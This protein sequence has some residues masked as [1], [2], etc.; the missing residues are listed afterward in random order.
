MIEAKISPS[1]FVDSRKSARDNIV[2][3]VRM[4]FIKIF[5]NNKNIVDFK[6]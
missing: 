2:F 6:L 1:I 5:K 4:N 3:K